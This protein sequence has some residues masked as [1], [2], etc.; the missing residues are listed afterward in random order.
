MLGLAIVVAA[1]VGVNAHLLP[2]DAMDLSRE[3]GAEWVRIDFNWDIGEATQGRYD[4]AVFDSVINAAHARGLHVF[5]SI[6]Y[7]PAWASVSHDRSSDGASND[8]PDP[9]AY[10]RFVRAATARYA[11]GRVEAW[12]PWNEPNLGDFF[13]GTQQEWIDNVFAPGVDAIRAGCPSCLV[14]GPELATIGTSYSDYL[15][16]A[17]ASRG[18]QLSA[19]SWH[20]YA[21]FPEMD[22]TAGGSRDSFYNK[23]DAHR[24]LTIG[25]TTYDIGRPSVRE[26][27]LAQG[28]GSLPV[29]VTETGRNEGFG[30]TSGLEA[31]RRYV[32]LVMRAM[33]CRPWWQHTFFYE[34]SEEH[35]AG[36]WPD[37]HWGLALRIADADG[38]Y[39][40]NFARKPAFDWLRAW[41][42]SPGSVD[43]T[44]DA[45]VRA[46][47]GTRDA[48][49][50]E[51]GMPDAT[52]VRA[53]GGD[54][55]QGGG[56]NGG[57]ACRA[58]G[59]ARRERGT[60]G[61]LVVGAALATLVGQTHR[62]RTFR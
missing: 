21:G 23:L 11:D 50:A 35:P 55:A 46:D 28:F 6:G 60:T 4:W 30:N 57:C 14:V 16:A 24:T 18:H 52:D 5:A 20:I 3:L 54:A 32:E 12:G 1:S 17:L 19:V 49:V 8:V 13:E 25:G 41:I 53:E 48:S 47:A 7:G 42:A 51:T 29:W 56:T 36:M 44:P 22:P 59:G 27:L 58:D 15:V 62:R 43:C 34:I 37:N 38:T 31:Q 9:V 26:V 39:A 61:W 2:A 40:D 45:G 33:A 10:A